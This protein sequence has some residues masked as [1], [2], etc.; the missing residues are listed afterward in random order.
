[1]VACQVRSGTGSE[2]RSHLVA[3]VHVSLAPVEHRV[4]L[5]PLLTFRETHQ[6]RRNGG[7]H[8]ARL[9]LRVNMGCE[10]E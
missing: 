4:N 6:R 7:T 9:S 3:L 2:G 5:V 8:G 10:D 1:V